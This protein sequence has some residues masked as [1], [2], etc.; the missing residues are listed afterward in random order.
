M[1]FSVDIYTWGC[2]GF[3]G[4]WIGRISESGML[5]ARKTVTSY[6]FLNGKT[7]NM[8]LAA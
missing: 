1:D 7:N 4:G 2:K 6:L 8:A 3:D 5:P